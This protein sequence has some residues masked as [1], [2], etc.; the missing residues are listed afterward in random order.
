MHGN[1]VML[2]LENLHMEEGTQFI[3]SLVV[4]TTV[5]LIMILMGITLVLGI[6]LGYLI[7]S[8]KSIRTKSLINDRTR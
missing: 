5:V 3:I 1:M 4:S 6:A 2:C 7:I 8:K